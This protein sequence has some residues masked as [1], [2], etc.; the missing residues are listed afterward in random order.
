MLVPCGA[1]CSGVLRWWSWLSSCSSLRAGLTTAPATTPAASTT[2]SRP[3]S[4]LSSASPTPAA[5]RGRPGRAAIAPRRVPGRAPE[6]GRLPRD[7][8]PVHGA[9]LRGAPAA[10]GR[11]RRQAA[12]RDPHAAVL[13]L[14]PCRRADP[15]RGSGSLGDFSGFQAGEPALIKRGDCFFFQKAALAR[16]AGAVAALMVNDGPK[17]T[18]GSLFRFGRGIPVVGLGRDTGSGLAGHP[19]AGRCAGERRAAAGEPT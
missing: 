3:T 6:E 11:D 1:G 15:G 5:G 19:G 10:A 14:G 17:P 16:R 4:P 13:A 8:R 12:A 7:G 9:V 2:P 18:P